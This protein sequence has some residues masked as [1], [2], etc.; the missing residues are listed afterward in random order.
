LK[1]II[2]I[3]EIVTEHNFASCHSSQS[4]SLLSEKSQER[5][6]FT[7]G[8]NRNFRKAFISPST[9]FAGMA[10]SSFTLNVLLSITASLGNILILIALH[11][12][13]PLHSP[14]KLLFQCLAFT[15]LSVGLISSN[16]VLKQWNQH[17]STLSFIET[18][19]INCKLISYF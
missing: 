9:L 8:H 16:N 3:K 13:S 7:G 17:F 14:T 18:L 6:I 19:N 1:Q 10:I 5:R 2:S 12:V 4:L 15:D 11:K